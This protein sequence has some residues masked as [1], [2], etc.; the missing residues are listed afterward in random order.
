MA[1]Q[2][3]VAEAANEKKLSRAVD[4]PEFVVRLAEDMRIRS[5]SDLPLSCFIQQV[6]MQLAGKSPGDVARMVSDRPSKQAP[7]P[8]Y[9]S[10]DCFK[11]WAMPD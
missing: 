11:S 5:G 9:Q 7:I 10:S 6:R 2:N 8:K 3:Q 4:T 1:V